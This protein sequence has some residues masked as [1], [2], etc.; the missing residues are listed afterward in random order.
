MICVGFQLVSGPSAK[1]PRAGTLLMISVISH[2]KTAV[3]ETIV[4]NSFTYVKLAYSTK[5]HA[6]ASTLIYLQN[7]A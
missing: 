3:C 7:P 2:V 6:V 4:Y 5:S 1:T